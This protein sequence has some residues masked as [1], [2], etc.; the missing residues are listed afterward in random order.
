MQKL[1]QEQKER[2]RQ[3]KLSANANL[4]MAFLKREKFAK[5]QK[6]AGRALDLDPA[7]VKSLFRRGQASLALGDLDAAKE[8]FDSVAELDPGNKALPRERKKLQQRFKEHRKREQA[9]YRNL[10]AQQDAADETGVQASEAEQAKDLDAGAMDQTTAE[11]EEQQGAS[12]Q[13]MGAA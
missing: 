13:K 2:V 6:Y 4:S 10:F 9:T 7:H 11:D 5:A 12:E 1:T 3:L 8:D